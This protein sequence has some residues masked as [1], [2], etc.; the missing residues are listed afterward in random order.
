M[1]NEEDHLRI[2][3]MK[4]G[5]DLSAVYQLADQIDSALNDTLHFAFDSELGYLTQCPTNLGTGMRASLMLHLPSLQQNGMIKRISDNL[6][7]LGLTLRG[8]YGEG[9]EPVG[10][11]YQ[12]SNQVTLGLSEKEAIENL[13]RIVMQLVEEERN[14]RKKSDGECEKAR[15]CSKVFWHIKKCKDFEYGRIYEI[16]FQCPPW[17]G[18]RLYQRHIL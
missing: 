1:I 6:S 8:T 5:M 10:A 3:V 12:L 17:R 4:E 13:E 9:T 11:L 18:V 14:I 16:A 15:C 7:K 2:Q